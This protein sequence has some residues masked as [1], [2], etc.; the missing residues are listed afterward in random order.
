MRIIDNGRRTAG[1]GRK[2]FTLVEM[3]LVLA[4]MLV[5]VSLLAAGVMRALDVAARTTV[6]NEISGLST[7]I[8][9]F[10]QEFNI[11][12]IPSQILLVED[13]NYG[14]YTGNPSSPYQQLAIDSRNYLQQIFGNRFSPT[15]PVKWRTDGLSNYITANNPPMILE[16][17]HCLVFFLGGIP[18]PTTPGVWGSSGVCQG[19]STDPAHPDN[20]NVSTRHGPFFDFKASRLFND[21]RSIGYGK[22]STL[23]NFFVY[24]DGFNKVT[25]TTLGYTYPK[26]PYAF[27]SSYKTANN[28]GRYFQVLGSPDCPSLPFPPAR[29]LRGRLRQRRPFNRTFSRTRIRQC[30]CPP[31]ATRLSQPGRTECGVL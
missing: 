31:I 30:L 15:T 7:A 24:I 29:I 21:T 4:I 28:Y 22:G 11:S 10:K 25:P 3:L 26:Q 23:L 6:Q 13:G 1:E 5:L 16:G 19:F 12:Y 9:A 27:F 8:N 18:A 20:F 17:Q 14:F 2:G